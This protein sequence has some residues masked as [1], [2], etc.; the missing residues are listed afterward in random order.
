MNSKKCS[1]EE[2]ALETLAFETARYFF[3]VCDDESKG[4]LSKSDMCR[5]L[6]NDM[7]N[8]S[9]DELE[10]VFDSLDQDH[11][12]KLTMEE[13]IRGFG[14][15]VKSAHPEMLHLIE[16]R[17]SSREV[18]DSNRQAN[19]SSNDEYNKFLSRLGAKDIIGDTS[20]EYIWHCLRRE[21]TL[22]RQFE[23]M[24]ETLGSE[25][26]RVRDLAAKYKSDQAAEV[27]QLYADLEQQ[28][29]QETERYI[30]T[31][32]EKLKKI[33][34][35]M[36]AEI[37]NKKMEFQE[38]SQKYA[39]IE[40]KLED[41]LYD[42]E[43]TQAF[44][45]KLRKERDMLS[46]QRE[47][48]EDEL[49]KSRLEAS[50]L[51]N[52]LERVQREVRDERKR[53]AMSA[54]NVNEEAAGEREA[55][56]R[57]LEALRTQKLRDIPYCQLEHSAKDGQL[58][59]LRRGD[60]TTMESELCTPQPM[61]NGAN[62]SEG[63]YGPILNGQKKNVQNL[64]TTD[65]D[66]P[67]RIFKVVVAGD[68]GVG[69]TSFLDRFTNDRFDPTHQS[70]IGIDFHLRVLKVEDQLIGLQLWDTAGQ[71]RFRSITKQYFRKADA[72]ILMFDLTSEQSFKNVRQWLSSVEEVTDENCI[73]CIIGNKTDLLEQG[74]ARMH[75]EEF[76]PEEEYQGLYFEASAKT[77][78][79]VQEAMYQL[80]LLLKDANV[81]NT[82][83]N[84]RLEE[85]VKPKRSKC[86]GKS[87][88][89]TK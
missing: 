19:G 2:E 59:S 87:S 81:R 74:H 30:R 61:E 60:S 15:F 5:L 85:P 63:S 41:A 76:K 14:S 3:N 64:K 28:V 88:N 39:T 80:A 44:M 73:I 54:W 51:S 20:A 32:Q 9:A 21:P 42:K 43:K 23:N 46:E 75:R 16:Q 53:R 26:K 65:G 1:N 84:L 70:T 25:I 82:E 49:R 55:L 57:Q 62:C 52:Y 4:Y 48:L 31:E 50:E 86:C 10:M 29:K 34:W 71:E 18:N 83:N 17:R 11:N 56:L 67:D 22:L 77:G 66:V 37:E 8:L 7:C 27:D 69:K 89:N 38:L 6:K 58:H 13:F 68:S 79:S 36:E 12:G 33:K 78:D 47:V 72:V 40:S 45:D 35:S 24:L